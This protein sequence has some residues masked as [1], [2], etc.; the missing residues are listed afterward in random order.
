[1][2]IQESA[3]LAACSSLDSE[4]SLQTLKK[5]VSN[6]ISNPH[7][8]KF[9]SVS[10]AA[11]QKR[12]LTSECCDF[13]TS[14]GFVE[15]Q[16][17]LCF[18]RDIDQ[19]LFEG[20]A[21]IEDILEQRSQ[22]KHGSVNGAADDV[23]Q[24]DGEIQDVSHI[25][26]HPELSQEGNV[27]LH[28]VGPSPY[29]SAM[30]PVNEP[31]PCHEQLFV[32]MGFPLPK[33]RE[34]IQKV[35][36]I[37]DVE[38]V[39]RTLL[40][41]DES[42]PGDSLVQTELTQTVPVGSIEA[43]DIPTLE[44]HLS[45]PSREVLRKVSYQAAG[46]TMIAA[47][48]LHLLAVAQK[49]KIL[50]PSQKQEMMWEIQAGHLS[51]IHSA[52]AVMDIQAS[53][54]MMLAP[55]E[56]KWDC[57]ICFDRQDTIGWRCPSEHRFCSG[58]MQQH[59][60]A[61]AFPKCPMC[62]YSLSET[63]FHALN[64]PQPRIEA[65]REAKLQGAVDTLAHAGE[66][67][68][69]CSRADCPNVVLWDSGGRHRFACVM[70][71]ATPFCTKCKQTP[72]HYH[73]E[74][75][76]VQPLRE[77]WLAWISGGREDYYGQVR[78]AVESDKRNQTLYEGIAR[79]NELE[80]DEQWKAQNC[81]LCPSCNRP[82]SKVDGC[83]S[84]VCGR[85]YHGGDQ[86]P[87]CGAEFNWASAKPYEANV[88]RRDLPAFSDASRL[89]GRN[90]FHPF[91]TC[92]LCG[93]SG[94]AGLRFSCIHCQS[95]DVCST[96]EPRLADLHEADHVFEIHFES[97]FRCPWLPRGTEV[98]VVRCNGKAPKSLNRCQIDGLEGLSGR[99]T[100]RRRPPLE[101]YFVELDLGQ[102]QVE[103]DPMFLEPIITSKEAA[104]QL[105]L[106]TLEKD[107]EEPPPD[108]VA[109]RPVPMLPPA[110][111]I[112]T[113]EEDFA[114]DSPI[115]GRSRS[116]TPPRRI[117]RDQ[118]HRRL[119][120][121]QQLHRGSGIR[122]GDVGAEARASAAEARVRGGVR[123]VGQHGDGI[124]LGRGET[125]AHARVGARGV[126][127][128]G[129]GVRLGHG[130]TEA[131]ARGGVRGVGGWGMGSTEQ[132]RELTQQVEGSGARRDWF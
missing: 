39:L 78:T 99:V 108:A 44:R 130:E 23:S 92:S 4:L 22:A 77:Q 71:D 64:V 109:H 2:D 28:E 118:Q 12:G 81:R 73:A 49:Q 76:R 1:M 16:G 33:V 50:T 18:H 52:I 86:Q 43:V 20:L 74:C 89:R 14:L 128:H 110:P 48:L 114:D 7:D 42:P 88:A 70:C 51:A 65:F 90:V 111:N 112:E 131:R 61:V 101:G 69:R 125:E 129:G 115:S 41:L 106:K 9:R 57:Q 103:L 63:D 116:I 95:F 96:C 5:L 59:V 124:R 127:Q 25:L 98:H 53:P 17:R 94:L 8:D 79:H 84:M 104:E 3:A 68:I 120:P 30:E 85:A 40:T 38:V 132:V 91:T 45:G 24:I 29:D 119:G 19:R 87:G 67:V 122:L 35:G 113:F 75:S 66:C 58:C 36:S 32:D 72:Y 107:G 47:H 80:A 121:G 26:V 62:D 34:A 100:G 10:L 21:A 55:G 105:L 31:D 126:G 83:D 82:I 123:G 27:S 15:E 97:E 102:G 13:L 6:V 11:L 37:E 56:S 93:T 46:S 54:E 117:R 60:E